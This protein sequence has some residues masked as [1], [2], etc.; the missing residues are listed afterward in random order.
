MGM[1]EFLLHR[2]ATRECMNSDKK[3]FL[4]RYG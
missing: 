3:Q 4:I 2:N 1:G